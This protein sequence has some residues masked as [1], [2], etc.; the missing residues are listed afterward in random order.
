VELLW[1]VL[2]SGGAEG[3]AKVAPV[4]PSQFGSP[5]EIGKILYTTWLF[6][7]EVT[8]ILLLIAVIGAVVLAKRKFA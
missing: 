2:S 1:I 3:T 8:S 7:F 6:P 4:L 5:A